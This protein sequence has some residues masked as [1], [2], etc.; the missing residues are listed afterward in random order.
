MIDD[1]SKEEK[2]FDIETPTITDKM[3]D[4]LINMLLEQDENN[5]SQNANKCRC[6]PTANNFP[7]ISKE[8]FCAALRSIKE[9]DAI[10]EEVADSMQKVFDGCF[11]FGDNKYLDALLFVLK[12]AIND[13]YDY[14]TWW[15][16]DATDDFRVWQDN[17]KQEWDL[18]KPE[19]LY[20]YI[21]TECQQKE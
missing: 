5:K 6:I 18:T 17:P 11:V 19:A 21:T 15:L 13:Q 10:Y 7:S 16:Y 3:K 8:C 4:K 20:D 1:N 9:Q 2:D 14:I 12:E